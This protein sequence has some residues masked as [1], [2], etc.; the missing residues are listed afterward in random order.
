MD[1]AKDRA[2][3]RVVIFDSSGA[4]LD[5]FDTESAEPDAVC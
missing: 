4:H 5:S 2:N 3:K 1:A